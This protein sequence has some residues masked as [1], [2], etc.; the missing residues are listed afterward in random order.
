MS[1][2]VKR[3]VKKSPTIGVKWLRVVSRFSS[4][5]RTA[6]REIVSGARIPG[7]SR[8]LLG[9]IVVVKRS[10]LYTLRT[11]SALIDYTIIL[12]LLLSLVFC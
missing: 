10:T 8:D 11:P 5:S 6:V 3:R 2:R 1:E 4:I 9:D 12:L 7:R